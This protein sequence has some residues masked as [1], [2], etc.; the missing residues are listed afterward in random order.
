M[1]ASSRASIVR[2][3]VAAGCVA[4]DEEAVELM[5]AAPDAATLEA[6]VLRREHG[7]PLAWITGEIRFCGH[8]VY[9]DQGVY[10][11]RAQ[12]EELARRSAMRLAM[13]ERPSAVDLCTGSGAIAVHLRAA[14]PRARVIGV[15]VDLRAVACAERNGVAAVVGDL[16]AALA[17]GAFDVVSAVA[18]YVPTS[19]LGL[20]PR[21]VQENEPRLA[22]DGGSDG[23]AV[24]RRLV[25]C[26]AALLRPGGW[27][28]TE[29][30]GDE[31]T[32]LAPTLAAFGFDAVESWLDD[33]HCLRGLA[34]RRP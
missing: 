28:L 25:E 10:V 4:A 30:G 8:R 16:G 20:L 7:E 6:N 19:A 24:V 18:P 21:D 33:E 32:A 31:D 1:H 23:L 29:V 11:P 2:R 13:V 5:A 12:S 9:V 22:L 26:A 17:H 14:V 15:D 27:L 34:A 3:L